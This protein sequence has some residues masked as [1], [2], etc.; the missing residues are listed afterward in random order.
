VSAPRSF[1]ASAHSSR[2]DAE[3]ALRAVEALA[4]E[5]ILELVDAAVVVRTDSGRVELHQRRDVSP[6]EG[7]VGGGVIGVVAGLVF[8]LPFALPAAGIALG[9]GAGALDRGIDNARMRRLGTDLEPGHA[10][11]CALVGKADWPAA[12]ERMAPHAG[13]LLVAE[14]SPEAAAALQ[15]ARAEG[16]ASGAG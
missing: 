2:R 12:R 6:G 3:T 16:P 14:L 4:D 1:V 13:E 10:A 7:A 15:T 5:G 9:A 8:G 11:L